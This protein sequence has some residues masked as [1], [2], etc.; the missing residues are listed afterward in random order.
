MFCPALVQLRGSF[1]AVK[2]L[3]ANQKYEKIA[4]RMGGELITPV[5]CVLY[6]VSGHSDPDS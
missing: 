3:L 6:C 5:I 1:L 4:R 2:I